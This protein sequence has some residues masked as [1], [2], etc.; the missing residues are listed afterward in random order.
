[1]RQKKYVTMLDPLQ[2]KYG[3]IMGGFLY[4]PA[5]LGET[6]WSAAILS[7]LGATLTVILDINMDL[8]VIISALIAVAYT[9]FGGL[10]SVAYTDVVQ[11]ICIFIGL[12]SMLVVFCRCMMMTS[13]SS[14]DL[15]HYQRHITV[16]DLVNDDPAWCSGMHL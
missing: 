2:E 9:F 5:L 3:N 11:L 13:E 14:W 6:F 15:G 12:V 16:D 8:S 4:I 10:Y 1:M 7:A